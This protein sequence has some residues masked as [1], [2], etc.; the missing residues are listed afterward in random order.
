[1]A[2]SSVIAMLRADVGREHSEAAGLRCCKWAWG[3][4]CCPGPGRP[5]PALCPLASLAPAQDCAALSC[6]LCSGPMPIAASSGGCPPAPAFCP[7]PCC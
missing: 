5:L 3:C 2:G 1:M 7:L 6:P 4:C